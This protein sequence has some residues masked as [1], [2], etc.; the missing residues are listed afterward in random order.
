MLRDVLTAQFEE[1]STLYVRASVL[2]PFSVMHHALFRYY[3]YDLFYFN[4]PSEMYGCIRNIKFRFF[5]MS[6]T[7]IPREE[8]FIEHLNYS[9]VYSNPMYFDLACEQ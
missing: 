6:T 5:F 3:I 9:F 1:N 2:C 4:T 7:A 8:I